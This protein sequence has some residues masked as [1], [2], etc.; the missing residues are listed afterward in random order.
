MRMTDDGEVC[1]KEKREE[2]KKTEIAEQSFINQA[3]SMIQLETKGEKNGRVGVTTRWTP[4]RWLTQVE[5][6]STDLF[7][8]TIS[9]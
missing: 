4:W 3:F 1:S 6:Y 2:T 7:Q 8:N 9:P 5:K